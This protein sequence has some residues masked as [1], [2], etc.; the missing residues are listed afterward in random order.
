MPLGSPQLPDH[1]AAGLYFA[2]HAVALW[3]SSGH[4]T[5]NFEHQEVVVDLVLQGTKKQSALLQCISHLPHAE[6]HNSVLFKFYD[7]K[8]VLTSLPSSRICHL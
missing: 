4:A 3:L 2:M 8:I 1:S 5:L 7:L 6:P